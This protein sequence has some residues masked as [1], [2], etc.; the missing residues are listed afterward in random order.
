MEH[1]GWRKSRASLLNYNH[2]RVFVGRKA[3]HCV[4][5]AHLDAGFVDWWYHSQA[6][7]YVELRYC[8]VGEMAGH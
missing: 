1:G 2:C 7:D 4:D 6:R 3:A 8:E 5:I